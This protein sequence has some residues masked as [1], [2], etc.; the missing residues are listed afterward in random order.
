MRVPE[1]RVLRKFTPATVMMIDAA[2]PFE[3]SSSVIT[4]GVDAS[5]RT[6]CDLRCAGGGGR[7]RVE[8]FL[9][10]SESSVVVE[11]V[12]VAMMMR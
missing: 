7:R 10:R 5:T 3:K 2:L 9:S 11:I 12:V 8:P 4:S 1:P 6:S